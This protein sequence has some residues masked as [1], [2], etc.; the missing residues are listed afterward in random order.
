MPGFW[1]YCGI[2]WGVLTPPVLLPTT[3]RVFLLGH[4][5]FMPVA[6]FLHWIS[7]SPGV[8]S[9]LGS[10]LSQL[11]VTPSQGLCGKPSLL[12]HYLGT[13]TFWNLGAN[14]HE[15]LTPSS[16]KSEKNQC[17]VDNVAK[18]CCWLQV[19]S[20][21]LYCS[22]SVLCVF[23]LLRL[24]RHFP[25]QGTPSKSSSAQFSPFK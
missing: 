13:V 11:H 3:H 19:E 18:L 25:R 1:S 15:P 2:I 20:G 6:F 9:I 8:S 14:C 24:G 23:C 4:L 7:Q 21:P 16:F 5:H 10:P 22:C 17:H 12:T